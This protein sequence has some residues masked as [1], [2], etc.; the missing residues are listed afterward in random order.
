[1]IAVSTRVKTCH[2]RSLVQN[3]V[4]D[5]KGKGGSSV[6][7]VSDFKRLFLHTGAKG[8]TTHQ[9]AVEPCVQWHTRTT[10]REGP[11]ASNCWTEVP[12]DRGGPRKVQQHIRNPLQVWGCVPLVIVQQVQ[13]VR[14]A[15]RIRAETENMPKVEVRTGGS[16][17][18]GRER[19][20]ACKVLRFAH[21]ESMNP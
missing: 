19:K 12:H 9:E 21:C 7:L 3:A 20:R 5:P 18:R 4:R 13:E 16:V 17:F 11:R 10:P 15:G 14:K 8:V 2:K 1:M 6:R